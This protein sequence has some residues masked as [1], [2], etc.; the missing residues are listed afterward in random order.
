MD[1]YDLKVGI[2]KDY[3]QN[4]YIYIY[5]CYNK[6]CKRNKSPRFMVIITN[7]LIKYCTYNTYIMTSS[8]YYEL[9]L[10]IIYKK[11]ILIKQILCYI[12]ISF[13]ENNNKYIYFLSVYLYICKVQKN[14]ES[15]LSL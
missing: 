4:I 2:Y 9:L 6:L 15:L 8:E 10:I 11:K 1:K 5:I 7:I 3:K 12:F 14:I 13:E